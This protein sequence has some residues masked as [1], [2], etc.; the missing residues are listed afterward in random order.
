MKTDIEKLLALKEKSGSHSPSIQTIQEYTNFDIKV[1]ACFLSNP[2]ATDLF[3]E[4]L[5]D[6]IIKKNKLR[7]LLE[8]YPPQNQRIAESVSNFENVQSSQVFVGN[9]AIEVIQA[10]I[11][12]FAGSCMAVPIPTFSSYYEF[13]EDI[14][15]VEFYN[16]RKENN[17][18]LDL[19]DYSKFLSEKNC[20]SAVLINPNNPNGAYLNQEE[21]EQFL[22]INKNLDLILLDES[23]KH[24][25]YE[26]ASLSS[27]EW[28][29]IVQKYP[30][31]IIVK[32][33]SKDFGVAGLRCGYGIM[34]SSRVNSLLKNG[35]LWNVSGLGAYFLKLLSSK[36]FKLKYEIIRKK[37]IMNTLMF[38]NEINSISSIKLYPSKANFGLIEFNSMTSW[39]LF[40][41]LIQ[42]GIYVRDCS[43]KIGLDGNFIRVASRSFEENLLIIEALKE[44]L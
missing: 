20:S 22:R 32:S 13:A 37:Y 23:F 36:E 14:C 8:Y 12:R 35:F 7:D 33:L 29:G 26:D 9:G 28:S 25:A 38:F 39:E 34:S 17:F 41:N 24:F 40:C 43:D 18:I 30:N 44:T 42:R 3:M 15:A 11:H 27:V 21:I 2:Y 19:D 31:V 16:L 4:Y 6:E 10:T 5:D 1:D